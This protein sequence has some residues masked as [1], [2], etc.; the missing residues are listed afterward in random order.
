MIKELRT[1][2]LTCDYC[3][4]TRIDFQS[5]NDY[6]KFSDGIPQESE[7]PKGWKRGRNHNRVYMACPECN[8]RA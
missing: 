2:R 4:K 5:V 8:D 1:Y 7:T 6:G 3:M